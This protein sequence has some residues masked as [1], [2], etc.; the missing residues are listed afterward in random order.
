MKVKNVFDEQ[1]FFTTTRIT[2]AQEDGIGASIG[3]GFLF[4]APLNDGSDRSVTLLISN[5]HVFQNPLGTLTFTFN[6]KID[7]ETPDYGNVHTFNAQDFSGI[8]TEHPDPSVDL[9]CINASAITHP[10]HNIFY[11]NLKTD[12][13]ANFNEDGFLPGIDVW[14]IGYPENRFDVTNNL[15]LMRRGYVSSM[16][17]MNFNSKNQFV[18]DAQVF[19]GSSG[20]PVFSIIDGVYK[21]I[22][23][24]TETMIKHGHLQAIPT[25]TTILGVQQTLGLGIVLKATLLDAL[26]STAVGKVV[27]AT[28]V[29]DEPIVE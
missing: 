15:P 18:I 26:I 29:R 24:V 21:L 25:S 20:S 3:T 7:E 11:K 4:N 16:P 14:F 19:Q 22:G 6:K 5:K 23:V 1:V 9:A 8:Y 27:A 28:M 13:V 17:K 10:E 12:L 2:I